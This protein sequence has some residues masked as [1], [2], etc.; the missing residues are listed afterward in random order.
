MLKKNWLK[1]IFSMIFPNWILVCS[2]ST[3][4]HLDFLLFSL[5]R[6]FLIVKWKWSTI[7]VGTFLSFLVPFSTSFGFQLPVWSI[8]LC[9]TSAP[10]SFP[11]LSTLFSLIQSLL[12]QNDS[13]SY[14]IFFSFYAPTCNWRTEQWSVVYKKVLGISSTG[15]QDIL[16]SQIVQDQ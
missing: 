7:L 12:Y 9:W 8:I 4:K 16:T 5:I 13:S 11:C 1:P 15:T 14:S 6:D 10:F 2:Y 3:L